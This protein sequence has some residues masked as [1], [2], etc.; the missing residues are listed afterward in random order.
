ML[1]E[2]RRRFGW[3]PTNEQKYHPS[4]RGC[5]HHWNWERFGQ[6]PRCARSALAGIDWSLVD[7]HSLKSLQG[8]IKAAKEI[9]P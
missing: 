5:V 1:D 9:A 2:I 7:E 4:F 8:I 3:L 6:C